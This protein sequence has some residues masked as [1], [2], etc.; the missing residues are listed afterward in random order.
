MP[1]DFP[2]PVRYATGIRQQYQDSPQPIHAQGDKPLF[3][4]LIIQ[5]GKSQRIIKDQD[6]ISE[7]YMMLVDIAQCF[8]W[9]PFIVHTSITCTF[10]HQGKIPMRVAKGNTLAGAPRSGAA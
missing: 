10:V 4:R 1:E 2:G 9:I 3:R 7:I 5:N 8:V 6:R